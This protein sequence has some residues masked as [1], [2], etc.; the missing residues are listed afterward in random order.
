[1]WHKLW[2]NALKRESLI[3]STWL[4]LMRAKRKIFGTQLWMPTLH[5]IYLFGKRLPKRSMKTLYF[6]SMIC[7]LLSR[8]TMLIRAARAASIFAPV[9]ERLPEAA[10]VLRDDSKVA[11]MAQDL[12]ASSTSMKHVP[13]KDRMKQYVEYHIPTY[14]YLSTLLQRHRTKDSARPLFVGVSAPQVVFLSYFSPNNTAETAVCLQSSCH[15]D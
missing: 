9:V 11:K 13:E 12:L 6:A 15:R 4:V 5:A 14:E 10:A 7:L 2:P 8:S 1:M 3:S